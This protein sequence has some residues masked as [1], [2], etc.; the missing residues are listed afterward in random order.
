MSIGGV[1]RLAF[2]MFPPDPVDTV[3]AWTPSTRQGFEV[4]IFI[5]QL[6]QQQRQWHQ[7]R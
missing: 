2:S 4:K 3:V 5:K 6:V 1:A 7:V